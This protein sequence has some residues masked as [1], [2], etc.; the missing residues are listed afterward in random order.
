MKKNMFMKSIKTVYLIGLFFLLQSTFVTGQGCMDDGGDDPIKLMGYIQPQYSHIFFKTDDYGNTLYKPGN[1][2]FNR[3]RIGVRGAIPYDVSY[4]VMAELTPVYTGAPFLLDAFVTYAPLGKYLKFSMGQFKSPF[5]LEVNTPCYALYTINRTLTENYLA[6]PFR[7]VG[8]MILGSTD[9]LFGKKDLVKYSFA[10]MNGTGINHWDDNKYKDFVGRVVISPW[11]WL[12]FGGSFRYGK[13]GKAD[14]D[15]QKMRRNWGVDI[16]F[17][18]NNFLVQGEYIASYNE[19][20][21]G[22]GGGCGGKKSVSA[23]TALETYNRSGYFV[24]IGYMTPWQLQPVVKYEF[25]NPDGTA[26]K[27][28]YVE[29]DF[30]QTTMTFGLNYFLND[31]TRIQI[32][33]LRNAEENSSVE[34]PNDALMIQVQAKF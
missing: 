19:G 9:T 6:S 7:D 8:F 23:V 14:G 22:G 33:Y 1:F 20:L 25:Y 16:V 13:E 3:A 34:F 2:Y 29:Q 17:D 10:L 31:W 4:Y 18:Y 11:E 28:L 5:G 32:N 12:H 21:I 27:Y 24:M 26:Y 30:Q 15:G